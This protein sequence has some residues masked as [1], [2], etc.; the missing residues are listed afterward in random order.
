MGRE[1]DGQG[2]MLGGAEPEYSSWGEGES[3]R[4]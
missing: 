1:D 3:V 4:R 2:R